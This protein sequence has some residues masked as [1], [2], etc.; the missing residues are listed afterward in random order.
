MVEG[1]TNLFGLAARS[2]QLKGSVSKH[3]QPLVE[4]GLVRRD[5]VLG[6]R[7]EVALDLT[8]DSRIP[9]FYRRRS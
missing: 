7:K 6:N 4:A 3:I 9:A 5:A 2:P 8:D 1:P